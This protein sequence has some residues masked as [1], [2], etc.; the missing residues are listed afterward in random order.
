MEAWRRR[1]RYSNGVSIFQ[2]VFKGLGRKKDRERRQSSRL[3]AHGQVALLWKNALGKDRQARAD[4]IETSWGGLSVIAKRAVPLGR[5]A[6]VTN[7]RI[8]VSGVVRHCERQ[9]RE[10]TMG[11]EI[12]ERAELPNDSEHWRLFPEV[13]I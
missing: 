3:P 6:A 4:I 13:E 12:H 10:C 1:A 9:G 11:I 2:R 7:G 5:E 8:I